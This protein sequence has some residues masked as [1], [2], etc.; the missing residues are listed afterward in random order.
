VT[1]PDVL[2]E[3]MLAEAQET[4]SGGRHLQFGAWSRV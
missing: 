4:R 1:D 2:F 3:R